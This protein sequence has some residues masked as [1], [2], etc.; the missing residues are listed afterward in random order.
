MHSPT[1]EEVTEFLQHSNWIEG[2]RSEEAVSYARLAWERAVQIVLKQTRFFNVQT[3]KSIHFLLLRKLNPR[4]AGKFRN[5]DV[6]IGGERKR[7]ISEE[8][9]KQDLQ[10][11]VIN[12]MTLQSS[13]EWTYPKLA[14]FAAKQLHIAFEDI[15]PF[16]D[17]NGRVGR[18]LYNIHRL[19]LGLPLHIIHEGEEQQEYYKW[20][21][22]GEEK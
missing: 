17:G 22:K 14:D 5:C 8:L 2:E 16:E 4:I 20:F 3:I 1:P 9:I 19:N 21:Q 12:P 15:H 18:I 11:R 10:E 6:M 13:H 7:F